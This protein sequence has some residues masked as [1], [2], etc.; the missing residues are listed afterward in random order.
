MA[1]I[2][3]RYVHPPT[4]DT[5]T[6]VTPPTTPPSPTVTPVAGG[7]TYIRWGRTSCP[8]VDGTEDVYNGI[9][10]GSHHGHTGG[11]SNYICMVKEARYHPGARTGSNWIYGTEYETGG[12][13]LNSQNQ[14]NV[15]CAVCHVTTRSAQLMIPG[16]DQYPG[17]WTSEY[18][19]WLMS[20]HYTTKGRTMYVCVDKDA[21]ALPGLGAE[22]DGVRMYHTSVSCNNGIPCPPFVHIKDLACVVCT[23]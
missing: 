15:P 22:N 20:E 17:G 14:D 8:T 7:V 16:T 1:A 3:L 23:K 9:T 4:T 13:F 5:P 21:Q 6:T 10:A 19:G 18:T 2:D 11:G 12:H